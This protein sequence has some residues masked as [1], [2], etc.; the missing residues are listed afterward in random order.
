MVKFFMELAAP[1]VNIFRDLYFFKACSISLFNDLQKKMS[2]NKE[3]NPETYSDLSE[4]FFYS[5][6][7]IW[8]AQCM[9]WNFVEKPE[10]NDYVWTTL[11]TEDKLSFYKNGFTIKEATHPDSVLFFIGGGGFIASTEKLQE[12]FLRDWCKKLGV[13][14]FEFHYKLAPEFKYPYQLHEML[15]TYLGIIYY[16]KHY[17]GVTLKKIFL[18]GDS[19]GGN[20]ALGLTNLLILFKQRV[21][22]CLIMVYPATNLC[23][24]RFTPSL[25][26]SFNERLLYF[27]VLE[28]CLQHYISASFKPSQDWLLSPALTPEHLLKQY[29]KTILMCGEF[30]P[31]FDDCY[32]FGHRLRQAGIDTTMYNFENMYHGFLAFDLPFGQ[33]ISEVSKVHDIIKTLVGDAL[34]NTP[35]MG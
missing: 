26:N 16:Y 10:D 7:K 31:L 21:P 6:E 12:M 24:K 28:K 19:A 25:L 15:E 20:L 2:E 9:T 33:G 13:S 32:R 29:P 3:F 18:M 35:A 30:D 23:D 27:T 4:S 5:Y 34:K 22:D 8:R 17:L 1:G 14:V 11:I